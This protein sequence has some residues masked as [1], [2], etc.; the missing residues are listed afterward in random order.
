MVGY[1]NIAEQF[2]KGLDL[3]WRYRREFALGDLTL[4]GRVS[5]ILDW[6]QQVF[7]ASSPTVLNSRIGRPETV[8]E[9]NVRFDHGDWTANWSVDYVGPTDND[10]FQA[11]SIQGERGTFL[12]EDGYFK[13]TTDEYLTHSIS[14]RRRMDKWTLQAGLQ[15]VFNE[16]PPYLGLNS[17]ASV[18][19]NVPLASQYD[20]S[21]RTAFVNIGR[22]F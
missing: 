15:N 20:W 12:G 18:I 9:L 8:G 13:R 17:G 3:N 21:G 6:T 19:G 22:T 11:A 16:N 10:K 14:I 1:K 5:H 7:V 2:N 4:S